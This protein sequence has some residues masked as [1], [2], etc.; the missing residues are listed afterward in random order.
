V[1]AVVQMDF[2]TVVTSPLRSLTQG[3]FHRFR[4]ARAF[5]GETAGGDGTLGKTDGGHPH[6]RQKQE[7][8]HSHDRSQAVTDVPAPDVI[9]EM[10]GTRRLELLTSTV[11]R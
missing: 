5:G 9:E 6:E 7:L 2:L 1:T 3:G 4:S 10:V 11:S 8:R